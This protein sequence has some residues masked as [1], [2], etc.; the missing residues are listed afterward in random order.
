MRK[1][2][3]MVLLSCWSGLLFSQTPVITSQVLNPDLKIFMLSDFNFTGKGTSAAE[4]FQMVLNNPTQIEHVCTL[5]L[6]IQ[7]EYQG[8]LAY[9]ATEPFNMSPLETIRITN[10]NLFSAREEFSLQ[11]YHIDPTGQELTNNLLATGRLPADIYYFIFDL[12]VGQEIVSNTILRFDI[13][14]PRNIDLISPGTPAGSGMDARI[15]TP[16]PLFRWESPISRFKLKI[17]ERLHDIQENAGPEEIMQQRVIFERILQ[18]DQGG[19]SALDAAETIP[20]TLYQYPVAGARPLESGKIYYWQVIGLVGTSGAPM[21]FPGEIW[22]FEIASGGG[23]QTLTPLQQQILSFVRELKPQLLAQDG[24]L[25]GFVPTETVTKN[26][27]P[28]SPDE[29][30]NTLS[31][32]VNGEYEL[33]ETRVE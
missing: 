23:T 25:Q 21:E 5:T 22:T 32:L 3:F 24:A 8:A 7:A 1:S 28:I 29:I 15:Y 2:L 30:L 9:G 20:S 14:N 17:A 33:L 16:F 31:K 6:H 27:V 12:K 13:T 4:I 19:G 11:E 18:V 26:S 10:R